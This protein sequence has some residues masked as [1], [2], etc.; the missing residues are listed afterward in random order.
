[1]TAS[2]EHLRGI[3]RANRLVVTN[4]KTRFPVPRRAAEAVTSARSA[5]PSLL[6][7]VELMPIHKR[8][9]HE[10]PIRSKKEL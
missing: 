10:R 9:C 4:E 3:A 5:D 1:M 8:Y 2:S 7:F 6:H